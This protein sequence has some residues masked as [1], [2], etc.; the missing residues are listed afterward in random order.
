MFYWVFRKVFQQKEHVS[1]FCFKFDFMEKEFTINLNGVIIDLMVIDPLSLPNYLKTLTFQEKNR[2]N[3]IGHPNK[4]LEFAA[5]RFLKHKLFGKVEI[6]YL[7]H[8]SPY[9]SIDNTPELISISH[10][11]HL[12]AICK[13][14]TFP[15]AIDLEQI[16]PKSVKLAHKFCSESEILLFDVNSEAEMTLL[17]SFKETLYKLSDRNGLIFKQDIIVSKSGDNFTGEVLMTKGK[18]SVELSHLQLEDFYL[19]CNHTFKLL[20]GSVTNN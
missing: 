13:N 1:N 20:H 19:T 17:W 15:V 18:L 12:T 2:F 9:I 16:G 5:S 4:K 3:N 11:S 6:Q 14:E 7:E 8:G 10:S